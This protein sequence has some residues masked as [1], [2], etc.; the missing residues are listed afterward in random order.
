MWGSI[1]EDEAGH[2]GACLMSAVAVCFT[3]LM[4]RSELDTESD[5]A[6]AQMPAQGHYSP[7]RPNEHAAQ[8]QRNGQRSAHRRLRATVAVRGESA[9]RA[10]S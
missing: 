9:G 4:T 8:Q 3:V 7:G 2:R 6:E 5:T 1:A 10:A